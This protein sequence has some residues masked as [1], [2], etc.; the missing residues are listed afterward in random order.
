MLNRKKKMFTAM[1]MSII[2]VSSMIYN[3]IAYAITK[4]EVE[5]T[6]ELILNYEFNESDFKDSSTIFDLS[7]NENNGIIR[8]M[9]L[10]YR[11]MY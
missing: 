4:D 9:V 5:S 6:K 1:A 11:I 7:G 3:N 8:G 10:L 2:M